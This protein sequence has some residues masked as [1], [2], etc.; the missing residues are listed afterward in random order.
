MS[1]EINPRLWDRQ[2]KIAL[3]VAAAVGAVL[4]VVWHPPG[5]RNAS[6][7]FGF[8]G[9][10]YGWCNAAMRDDVWPTLGWIVL[11]SLVGAGVAYVGRLVRTG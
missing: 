5:L 9:F 6:R 7:C 3:G 11:G 10:E 8:M 1:K 4:F 2:H